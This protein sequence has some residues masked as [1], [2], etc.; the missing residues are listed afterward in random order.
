MNGKS[1]LGASKVRQY[2]ALAYRACR[3]IITHPK[4]FIANLENYLERQSRIRASTHNLQYAVALN[5]WLPSV[6]PLNL[7]IDPNLARASHLNVLI[8]GMATRSMSGG[9]NTAINLTYRLAE[10]GIPIRYISTDLPMDDDHE[11]LWQHFRSLTGIHVRYSNVEITCGCN[12]AQSLPIGENDVFFGTAWW[13]VQMIKHA[14]PLT[15]KKKFIY[16]IQ[17]FEPG[18]YR[19]S[20]EYAL[21]LETYG[22]NFHAIINES[23]LAEHL[24]TNAVGRFSESGFIDQCAVFEPAVDDRKFHP[25]LAPNLNQRRRLLFYARPNAP[26]NLYELGI[27]ALKRA[28]ERRAFSPE[29]WEFCSIGEEIAPVDLGR[30]MVV[31]PQGWLD[32]ESYAQLLRNSDVGLSLMLSPHTSY[33]PLEMAASGMVVVTNVFGVKT[34]TRLRRLSANILPV[35]A[36]LDSIVEGLAVAADRARDYSSRLANSK[37]HQPRSWDESFAQVVPRLREMYED[38]LIT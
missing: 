14:L 7:V 23:L 37:I 27:L 19:W 8:P 38:C 16:I 12:R 15:R 2:Y 25:K 21:A 18:L 9:P 5:D 22:L 28:V 36:T 4:A 3:H 17:E 13:T 1:P 20:T 30:G 29:H 31:Q 11:G 6:L 32:Y 34:E 10:Y 35:H 24:C 26:R 33:P